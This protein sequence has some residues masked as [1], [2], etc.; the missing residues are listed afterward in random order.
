MFALIY[1]NVNQSIIAFI[2]CPLQ[3]CE[4]PLPQDQEE[5][6]KKKLEN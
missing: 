4:T 1:N 6:T 2:K 5:K 3:I